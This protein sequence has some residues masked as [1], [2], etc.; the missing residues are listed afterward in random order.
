MNRYDHKNYFKYYY[1]VKL[2]MAEIN[3]EIMT[4]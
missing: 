1:T 3:T 2:S 4:T